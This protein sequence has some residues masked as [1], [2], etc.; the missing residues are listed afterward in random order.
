VG[1]RIGEVFP[2]TPAAQAGFQE[3]DVIVSLGGQEVEGRNAISDVASE[4]VGE[5]IN[6]V[7][8]RDGQE[9]TLN[10]TPGSWTH[11][12][13]RT[14]PAGLGFGYQS[15]VEYQPVNPFVAI[16]TSLT[17]TWDVL[18]LLITGLGGMLGGLLGIN[19]PPP[20]SGLAGPI[21]IARA[22][23][24]VIEMSGFVGFWE[25][26]AI[27]SLNLFVLNLLPI[28]ALDGS[29]I[30]FSIIEWLRGG[31]KIPPEKEAMVHFIGFATLIGL[32]VIVS[33]SDVWNAIQGVPVI[34]Q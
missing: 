29:H 7:V 25:W 8:Q 9:V 3:G 15:E 34:G 20:G 1:Q 13:G 10:V 24:Q 27:I 11:P 17:H 19:E 31:K 2:G 21:G 32:I 4:H 33:V 28:P 14:F 26:M 30:V 12:D 23:D 16:I 22:T 18:V 5:P 6:A